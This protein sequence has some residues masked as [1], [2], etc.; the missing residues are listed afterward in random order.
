MHDLQN[1]L[2]YI[3]NV[4]RKIAERLGEHDKAA[5]LRKQEAK[6]ERSRLARQDTLCQE[7]MTEAEKRWLQNNRPPEAEYWGLWTD[8]LPEH[9]SYAA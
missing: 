6:L 7:S 3:T 2:G 9:L 4:A 5:K 8:L 1:R